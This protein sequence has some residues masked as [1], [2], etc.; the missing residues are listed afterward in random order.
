M[1]ALETA[2]LLG[3]ALAIVLLL[4]I[5]PVVLSITPQHGVHEGDLLALP[6]F[7]YAAVNARRVAFATRL[8]PSR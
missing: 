6:A 7:V 4:K 3:L 1:R 8:Q 2:A 5:G